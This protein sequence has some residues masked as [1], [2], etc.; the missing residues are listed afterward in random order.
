MKVLAASQSTWL[1]VLLL[2]DINI[3]IYD[4]PNVLAANNISCLWMLLTVSI[5]HIVLHS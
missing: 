3:I 1:F 4:V 5:L 2:Y